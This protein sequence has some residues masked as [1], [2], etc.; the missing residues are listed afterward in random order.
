MEEMSDDLHNYF[1]GPYTSSTN[2]QPPMMKLWDCSL[3]RLQAA[4]SGLLDDR[5]KPDPHIDR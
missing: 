5:T 4:L 1:H 3:S 2:K